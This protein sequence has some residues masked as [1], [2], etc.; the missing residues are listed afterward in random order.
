[1]ET[2][3]VHPTFKMPEQSDQRVGVP[4]TV[5]ESPEHGVFEADTPLTAEIVFF[6]QAD[7]LSY[8]PMP[9]APASGSGAP[10]E[11]GHGD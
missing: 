11:K 2:D 9:S 6:K 10:P 5:I 8:G 7:D 3:E 4:D 1:M